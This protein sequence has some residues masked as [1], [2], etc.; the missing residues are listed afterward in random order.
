MSRNERN[1]EVAQELA[2][3]V[4]H[5]VSTMAV[6]HPDQKLEA[7]LLVQTLDSMLIVS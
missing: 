7:S 2:P 6:G 1:E 4:P 5:R 3:F